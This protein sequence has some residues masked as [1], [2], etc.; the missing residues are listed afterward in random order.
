MLKE[1]LTL[2]L[3]AGFG[4]VV[5]MYLEA[6]K[7]RTDEL[8]E[9]EQAIVAIN[10]RLD[11]LSTQVSPLWARVQSEI[12][13]ELHHPHPRY[14]EMDTLLEKLEALLIT[15]DERVRLKELLVQR[16][17]DMHEDITD[18]QRA[19]AKLMIGVMDKVLKETND[20]AAAAA[21]TKSPG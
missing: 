10:S 4:A 1:I 21:K 2:A 14:A 8:K 11:I 12:A 15:E 20:H 3:G 19:S 16:S 9:L 7:S 6:R 18:S 5:S 17:L 13:G